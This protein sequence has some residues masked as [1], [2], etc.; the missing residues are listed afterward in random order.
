MQLNDFKIGTRL[1]ATF[2]L[3]ILTMLAMVAT[4]LIRLTSVQGVTTGLIEEDWAKADAANT[5]DL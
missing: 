1:G 4:G 3:L 2:A 5:V